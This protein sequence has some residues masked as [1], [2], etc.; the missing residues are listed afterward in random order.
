MIQ[1][2]FE[3]EKKAAFAALGIGLA[4]CTIG[5]ALLISAQPPFYTGLALALLAIG[6]LET[7]V[8]T[9]VARRSDWQAIDLNKMLTSNPI[10]FVSLEAPRM[11]KVLRTFQRNK[12]GELALIMVGLA[13]ILFCKEPVFARGFGAG[14]FAQALIMLIFDYFAEKRGKKYNAYV[15]GLEQK[16]AR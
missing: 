4:A 1:S 2:Y 16:G 13:L 10:E 9:S 6:I 14:L 3:A 11:E 15:N 7:I 12:W 5:S 8:G